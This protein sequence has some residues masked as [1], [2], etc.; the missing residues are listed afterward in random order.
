MPATAHGPN[1]V[2]LR[3]RAAVMLRGPLGGTRWLQPWASRW[4]RQTVRR[5]VPDA[6][7]PGDPR[8]TGADDSLLTRGRAMIHLPQCAYGAG[9]WSPPG[10]RWS[11]VRPG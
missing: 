6:L 5:A 4:P 11:T 7:A 9:E 10:S 2:S 8:T 1:W 3:A